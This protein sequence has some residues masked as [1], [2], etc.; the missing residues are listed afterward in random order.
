MT[1]KT[2]RH[3]SITLLLLLLCGIQPVRA[4]HYVGVRGGFGGGTCAFFP[5]EETGTVWGLYSGGVSWKYYS[6]ERYIGGIEVDALLMQQGFRQYTTF[7]KLPTDTTTYMDRTVNSVMVPIFWQP[8][9][10]FFRRSVRVF[11]N[12]G[13]TFS[14]NIDS[15]YSWY[16]KIEGLLES[17]DYPMKLTRDNRW[18]YGLC[19]GGGIGVSLKRFELLVEGRYYFGYGDILR[20]RNKY[21]GN[22]LRS[23]LNSIQVS[24]GLYYRLGKGG[25]LAPPSKRVAEKIR[26]R[27]LERMVADPN[28]VP[29][30]DTLSQPATPDAQTVTPETP[31]TGSDVQ[32]DRKTERRDRKARKQEND[33]RQPESAAPAQNMENHGNDPTTE[34]SQ[35]D[36]EG[37]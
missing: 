31:D 10:Y 29:A 36:T 5:K 34:S 9:F 37:H 30:S 28:Y 4:Q 20:N 24:A 21:E 6:R 7:D 15:H 8:H 14:Y 33:N 3:I 27:E 23:P 13:V 32:A 16:S 12:L 17:H 18:G 26:R 35:T 25:I 19:G 22:P 1:G 11:I 2:A